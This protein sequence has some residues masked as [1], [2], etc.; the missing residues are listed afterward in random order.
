MRRKRIIALLLTT[1][2]T[3]GTVFGV[4]GCGAENDANSTAGAAETATED[5]TEA[6]EE[7]ATATEITETAEEE[8]D[9]ELAAI[10]KAGKIIVG[11]EGTY[12]PFT[13]HDDDGTL[14]GYDVEVA[15]KIAEYLGVEVEFVES[16]WDSLLAG[17]DSGRL[18]TVIN[19]VT[20]TDERKEKYDFS[21]PYYFNSRQITV[22]KGN[23]LN[24]QS[25]EDLNGKKVATNSTNAYATQFEE[26]GATIIPIDSSEEQADMILSGR[27]DFGTFSTVTLADYQKQHPDAGIEVAFVIPDS[28]EQIAIPVRKGETRLLEQINE[29]LAQLDESGTLTEISIKYF[30][31]DYSKS[32]EN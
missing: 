8:I 30:N 3:A 12:P 21:N 28:E 4:T 2:I 13:Y 26:L 7:E 1:V 14:V 27:A 25:L 24:I 9:D 19:D 29:A 6:V 16:D 31:D 5:E 18:D 15:Q 11:V 10:Q 20:V 23:P 17:V 32:K 22:A